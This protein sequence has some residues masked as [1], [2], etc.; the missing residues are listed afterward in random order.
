M[1]FNQLTN[2]DSQ[3][4]GFQANN[5]QLQKL[6]LFLNKITFLK[7][8]AF[9][10]LN[11]LI[12]L[13]VSQNNI[14]DWNSQLFIFTKHPL[15]HLQLQSNNLVKI[16]KNTFSTLTNLQQ[17]NVLDN[18]IESLETGALREIKAKLEIFIS[19]SNIYVL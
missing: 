14:S 6:S 9:E 10:G 8:G 16:E 7:T 12:A 13:D 17:L 3:G 2:W 5:N 19:K 18:P 1:G 15:Q 11:K 4:V